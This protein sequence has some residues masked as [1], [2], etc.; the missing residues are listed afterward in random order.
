[1]YTKMGIG[2][3][4]VLALGGC[5]R[6][7]DPAQDPPTAQVAQDSAATTAVDHSMHAMG[8]SAAGDPAG[9]QGAT[10]S[11]GVNHGAAHGSGTA[12]IS[13]QAPAAVMDHSGMA[14]TPGQTG[15]ATDHSRMDMSQNRS[16][17]ARVGGMAG[18]DHS[19]MNHGTPS[20]RQ[21]STRAANHAE[22]QHG[23]TG[24]PSRPNASRQAGGMDHSRMSGMQHGT[25]DRTPPADHSRMGHAAAGP[26]R[27]T[28]PADHASMP[29]MQH[30]NSGT[31]PSGITP[32]MEGMRHG[33]TGMQ[34][35]TQSQAGTALPAGPG[36][37]KLLTLVRALVRDSVV[38][39]RIQ[40]DSV[41]SDRWRDPGVR[42]IIGTQP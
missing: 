4:A 21:G 25:S 11:A 37:E 41:L 17:G 13:G 24:T 32:E 19:Q 42:R 39:Q 7:S 12:G 20:G 1:M 15:S 16:A 33:P 10:D 2:L 29:G 9:G 22:M 40:Q 8:D 31:R 38:Q 3:A 36:T 30:Q 18:M 23:G 5:S 6:P 35:T 14:M 27:A 34:G 28:Q 26:G